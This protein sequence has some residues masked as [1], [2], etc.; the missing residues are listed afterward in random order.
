MLAAAATALGM[1]AL[2]PLALK[3]GPGLASALLDGKLGGGEVAAAMGGPRP[4]AARAA[5]S[6]ARAARPRPR[7]A[8]G[9]NEQV[10]MMELQRLVDKQK[11]MFA[12]IS[13]VLRAQHDTR[14]AI[15]GNVR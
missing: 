3:A 2:A 10:Q 14:M 13:N 7:A 6:S 4:P 11:E 9:K 12:M 1:P 5:S 15:I 8:T